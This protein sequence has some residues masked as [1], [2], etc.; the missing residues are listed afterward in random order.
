MT[1][2]T[3]AEAPQLPAI[4]MGGKGL[5]MKSLEDMNN[6]ARMIEKAGFAPAGFKTRAQICIALQYGAEL[7]LTPMASLQNLA[8]INGRPTIY[9]DA[10]TALVRASGKLE[11]AE[12]TYE[13]EL[14]TDS[15]EAVCKVWR[16]GEG[17]VPVVGRFSIADAK[18]AGLW[19]KAGPWKQ[20][21]RRMLMWRARSWAYRD[22][23][24]DVLKGLAF[25]EEMQDVP[26]AV[27]STRPSVMTVDDVLAAEPMEVD[28]EP[29]E[30]AQAQDDAR[31]DDPVEK[32]MAEAKAKPKG[33]AEQRGRQEP[34]PA[35]EAADAPEESAQAKASTNPFEGWGR[36]DEGH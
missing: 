20:Y 16:K 24:A 26:Y 22:A 21:P 3:A 28:V 2:T 32:P 18:L 1:E 13:G 30:E 14:G 10:G 31:S 15:Y 34:A 5:A 11:R 6:L 25:F 4:S 8:V 33:K 19:G 27:V 12:E 36:D 17:D 7:G 23:F 29:S 35:A 9:G